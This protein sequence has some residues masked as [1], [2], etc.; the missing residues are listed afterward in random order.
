MSSSRQLRRAASLLAVGAIAAITV[1][2]SGGAPRRSAPVSPLDPLSAAELRVA[3]HAI[4][5][6]PRF[7]KGAL[8][9][10]VRL[11][12]PPKRDVLSGLSV[13]RKAFANVYDEPRNR[14]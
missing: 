3:L 13:P 10:I 11:V 9:P 12:D 8:F 7:P 2:T 1:A 4:K 5:A 6:D 14:L